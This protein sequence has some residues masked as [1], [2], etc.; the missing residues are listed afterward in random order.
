MAMV[1]I[2]QSY[3]DRIRNLIYVVCTHE[4]THNAVALNIMNLNVYNYEGA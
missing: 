3:P 4:D 1:K 2:A